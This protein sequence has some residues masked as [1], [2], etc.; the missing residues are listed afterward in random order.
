[1]R[2]IGTG[3]QTEVY[4]DDGLAIK[5]YNSMV[6][7]KHIEYE[8]EISVKVAQAC[9]KAPRSYGLWNQDD[10]YGLKFEL[11][12]GE[13]LSVRMS[14]NI[15]HIKRYAQEIGKLHREVH[16]NSITGLQ[17]ATDKFEWRLRKY[18]NLDTDVLNNLLEFIRNSHAESLCHGDLHPD[19]IMIDKNH[20]MRVVDWVDAYCGN[21]L[22][23]VARTYYLLNHGVSP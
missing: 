1:M 19:N 12:K 8:A 7:V 4:E 18:K 3:R 5:V 23:D 17:L 13:M 22:S 15:L 16:K 21:P 11:I 9:K 14:R 2:K 20:E 10:R 6:S